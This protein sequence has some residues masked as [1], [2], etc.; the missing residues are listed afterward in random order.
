MAVGP[1][2]LMPHILRVQYPRLVH[3]ARPFDDRSAIRKHRELMPL[4]IELEHE[5][6]V[7]HLAMY[8]EVMRH[9]LEVQ[10]GRAAMR[11]LHGVAAAKAG[12]LRAE[13][14]FQPFKLPAL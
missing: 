8:A 1:A 6:V 14:T 11:D 5:A 13:I 10:L 3:V 2:R 12:R 4:G 9:L 7:I